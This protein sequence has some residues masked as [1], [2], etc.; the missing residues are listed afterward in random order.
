MTNVGSL[1]LLKA[2]GVGAGIVGAGCTVGADWWGGFFNLGGEG[3]ELFFGLFGTAMFASRVGATGG[4]DQYLG[5]LSAIRAY[6]FVNWHISFS[7]VSCSLGHTI[8]R[9]SA[10]VN[11]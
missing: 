2:S 11:R 9:L 4:F 3:G 8:T 5:Y 10:E 7:Y 1:G 6:I